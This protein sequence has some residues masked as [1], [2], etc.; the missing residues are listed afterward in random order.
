MKFARNISCQKLLPS[1]FDWPKP[2][3]WNLTFL[4]ILI[5]YKLQKAQACVP[6]APSY[7]TINFEVGLSPDPYAVDG[8]D[9]NPPG[10]D[11]PTIY[12]FSAYP[13][14]FVNS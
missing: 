14:W 7:D 8:W 13:I 12:F 10:C 3:L 1:K 4:A 11:D 9:F 2:S 5:I 6:I